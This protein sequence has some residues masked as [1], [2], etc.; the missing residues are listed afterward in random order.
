[1][2]IEAVRLRAPR[3]RRAFTLVELLV[4]IGIISVLIGLLLP[5]LKKARRTAIVL[6]S[7]IAYVGSDNRVHLTD[8]SGGYDT[9]LLPVATS[10]CPVCH[11]PPVWS[12][13]G[14][15]IGLQQQDGGTNYAA[16]LDPFA[17]IPTKFQNQQG[18]TFMT[19]LDNSRFLSQ[20]GSQTYE[21]N[22]DTGLARAALQRSD[23]IYYMATAS[24]NSPAPYIAAVQ[25]NGRPAVCFL[26]K[27]LAPG[28]VI[29]HEPTVMSGFPHQWPRVDGNGEFVGWTQ[30]VATMSQ[31]KIAWKN[32]NDSTN[33]PPTIMDGGFTEACFCDWTEQGQILANVNAGGTWK[34]VIFDRNTG[35]LLR[36]LPTA[37]PPAAGVIASWRKY[38]HQ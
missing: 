24:A 3:A 14:Q 5:A 8:P 9:M 7:P 13:S 32:V 12:P 23:H 18:R 15:L 6:A 17:Q 29:W 25:L 35:R 1:M 38:G 37:M 10:N 19:W 11:S 21:V 30:A 28:K 34:L 16:L 33:R 2:S 26:K 4:V 36:E 31:R 20:D 27:D 22:V